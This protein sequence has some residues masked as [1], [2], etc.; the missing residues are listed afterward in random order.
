M[1][2]NKDKVRLVFLLLALTVFPSVFAFQ[3]PPN[4]RIEYNL[5]YDWKF[6]KS[7]PAGA[8]TQSFD[9][10]KWAAVSLPH[11]YNDIDLFDTWVT[12]SGNYGWAGKTWYRKHFNL[13]ASLA[14]R[15]VFI[16]FEGIHQAGEF[17]I[18]GTWV[19]RH[20]NGVGPAGIDI[21]KFV[22]FG[23]QEN[24]LAVQVDNSLG[25][26]EAATGITFVWN[27]PPFFPNYGGI[28]SN[29]KLHVM[30]SVYQTLPLYSNLGTTGTY[31]YA[32]NINLAQSS[33]TITAE[34]QIKNESGVAKNISLQMIVVDN[35]GKEVLNIS[36][37]AQAIA[38]GETKSLTATGNLSGTQLWSP[39]Y[40]YLYKVFT[41]IKNGT[42]VLDV[43]E[44]PLGI[45][46]VAFTVA[47]GLTI[48][49]E[50][51]YLNGYAPRS[52]MEW[53]TV[54][55]AP[56]WLEEYDFKLMKE[57]NGNFLRPMH[58]TPHKVDITASDKFGVIMA[59]PAGDAE[60]DSTGRQWDM[61]IEMMRD[62]M[63]Y[64]RNNPS[65]IF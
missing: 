55:K 29:A 34:S 45:R 15:K 17:Y 23:S 44:N 33:A 62:A 20:E 3:A 12:G 6:I 40:P 56:N 52:T 16:E 14:G 46:Q 50:R 19:G 58:T 18:N 26:K 24:I 43:V 59:C 47:E 8:E 37:P 9:D 42:A 2:N 10:S 49:G 31:V 48:N 39:K 64:F 51:L 25:Y 57:S 38:I 13:D 65:V 21:S 63:I 7:S 27:T 54:G 36:N 1:L 22:R 61:R 30:D 53:V 35:T 41:I 4:N 32:S 28:L 5:D 60:G 11:T